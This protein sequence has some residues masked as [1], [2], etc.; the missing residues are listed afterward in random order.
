M[1]SGGHRPNRFS[2]PYKAV[3]INPQE[4]THPLP[5]AVLHYGMSSDE[6]LSE[7]LDYQLRYSTLAKET[8][9]M[10]RSEHMPHPSEWWR[11]NGYKVGH[12]Q[13]LKLNQACQI[14]F[15]RPVPCSSQPEI[16]SMYNVVKKY[17]KPMAEEYAKLYGKGE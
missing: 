10:P 17:N 11:Y 3:S 15:D 12:E 16:R 1:H 14:W 5:I 8:V 2:K 6:L 9:T 4:E 13:S 7:K